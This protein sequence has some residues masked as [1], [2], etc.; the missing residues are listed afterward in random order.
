M[1]KFL[2][3]G[4][5]VGAGISGLRN[6]GGSKRVA[7]ATAAIA[8]VGGTL[9]CFYFAFGD[10]DIYGILDA[11]DDAAAVAGSLLINSTGAV[12]I[13]LTPLLDPTTIDAASNVGGAYT[14]PGA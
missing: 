7:A 11:P 12:N 8:S 5:Y 4:N 9:D 6:E 1:S 10:S 2:I 3:R 14:P 13:S